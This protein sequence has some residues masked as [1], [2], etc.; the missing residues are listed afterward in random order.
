MSGALGLV[1]AW[2]RE[3]WPTGPAEVCEDEVRV[4]PI[5]GL[6]AVSEGTGAIGGQGRPASKLAVWS[7]VGELGA[8]RGP[9]EVGLDR[10]FARADEAV[11]RLCLGWPEGLLRPLANLA[12]LLVEGTGLWVAHIGACRVSRLRGG[13]LEALTQDHTLGRVVP[14]VPAAFV[15]VQSRWLGADRRRDH[16]LRRVEVE[17]GDRFLVAGAGL[18]RRLSDEEIAACAAGEPAAWARR[19]RAQVRSRS[20]EFGAL[21]LA[22][23]EVRRGAPG[24]PATPGSPPRRSWLYAP[25]EPL[26]APPPLA[27][28]PAGPTERWFAEVRR[29][30]LVDE[31]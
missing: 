6:V 14:D 10:G 17:P 8:R 22:A 16:E 9:A 24:S 21:V 30:V 15:H 19:L 3:R 2:V 5:A 27:A 31:A 20:P 11:A 13:V 26:P 12:A 18:H 28:L 23:V 7:L 25:G 29:S 4:D 1:G